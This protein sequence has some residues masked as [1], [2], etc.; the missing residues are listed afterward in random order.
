MPLSNK[1]KQRRFRERNVIVL[2]RDAAD[3][4]DDL[5]DRSPDDLQE[6]VK[7]LKKVTAYLN[8]HL[9]HPGRPP[10]WSR[11]GASFSLLKIK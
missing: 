9:R 10:S 4:A 11:K 7:K 3:I 8:D 2:T 1:E 5:M 6:V